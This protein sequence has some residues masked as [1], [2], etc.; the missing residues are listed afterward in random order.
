MP[1][2][3]AEKIKFVCQNCNK[4]IN[5]K[6]KALQCEGFCNKW[7]HIACCGIEEKIHKKINEINDKGVLWLCEMDRA[8]FKNMVNNK[9]GSMNEKVVEGF[10]RKFNEIQNSLSDL[11]MEVKQTTNNQ[12]LRNQ[13][14]YAE[15]LKN[16]KQVAK[17]S[18]SQ[19]LIIKPK[20][21]QSSDTTRTA[22]K[23][24][25]NPAKLKIPISNVKDIKNGG[26][27][28]K[29]IN[30]KFNK[31]LEEETKKAIGDNY[32]IYVTRTHKPNLII[33]GLASGYDEKNLKEELIN[34]NAFL[35]NSI[36]VKIV[37]KKQFK[38][39]WTLLIETN[40]STFNKM[41][42][43]YVNIGWDSH[44][45]KEYL[46]LR[47]CYKCQLYNHKIG[48]CI[49]DVFCAK[50]SGNHATADCTS[51]LLK[52]INCVRNSRSVTNHSA[53]DKTCPIY[54][55]EIRYLKDRISY[56]DDLC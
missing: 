20:N 37:H 29:T 27:I 52:C 7:F 44:Y 46:N 8:I 48:E 10:N 41:V 36:E 50:C 12:N 6:N 18:V 23:S 4:E 15:I 22:V 32:K 13:S 54:I 34:L 55:K 14:S 11:R 31:I 25:I 39:R 51:N 1:E 3:G 28:I 47:R 53:S 33:K 40:G 24:L 21:L 17:S 42:N 30:D 35:D 45:V 2:N 9:F 5:N 26:I 19:G 38:N 49:K 16:E 56:N 43:R